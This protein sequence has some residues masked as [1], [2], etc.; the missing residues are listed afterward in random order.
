MA[1]TEIEPHLLARPQLLDF[2]TRHG[3]NNIDH[4]SQTQLVDSV[5]YILGSLGRTTVKIDRRPGVVG[6]AR[7]KWVL[8]KAKNRAAAN[9]FN[10]RAVSEYSQE[11]LPPGTL[12]QYNTQEGQRQFSLNSDDFGHSGLKPLPRDFAR[13]LDHDGSYIPLLSSN[14]S[15]YY[16]AHLPSV[17]HPKPRKQRC[18]P[19][20]KVVL[21]RV[22]VMDNFDPSSPSDSSESE[23]D[24]SRRN[25]RNKKATPPTNTPKPILAPRLNTGPALKFSHKYDDTTDDIE[26]Y[27]G[28]IDLYK[29]Q[30]NGCDHYKL[31]SICV[32]GFADRDLANLIT[33]QLSV[34]FNSWSEFKKQL[35]KKLGKSQQEWKTAYSRARRQPSERASK[36]LMRLT[37]LFI[38]GRGIL[39]PSADQKSTIFDKFL[40]G[41]SPAA[42]KYVL[43]VGVPICY[44]NVA[45]YVDNWEMSGSLSTASTFAN[46]RQVDA[47]PAVS[48]PTAHLSIPVPSMT[49]QRNKCSYCH[50]NLHFTKDCPR[51]PAK[52]CGKCQS[53][54]HKF[55][56]CPKVP[57]RPP[58]PT[59]C[60]VCSAAGHS[61][62]IENCPVLRQ[63]IGQQKNF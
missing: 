4:L 5:K 49:F 36:F 50:N 48:Q 11:T 54:E 20:S 41:I 25:A 22:V 45:D 35:I 15:E 58:A 12:H 44:Y 40:E 59:V 9:R 60:Q 6:W 43:T 7:N 30:Y 13:S 55:S 61:A 2:L 37:G 51:K 31:C 53:E 47:Q 29:A 16:P 26:T 38:K 19:A 3:Y 8:Y 24:H 56:D 33:Q 63:Q 46:V 52:W 27:L 39:S 17:P 18:A 32:Y 1:P 10:P 42:R 34:Y 14:G 21:P 28:L 57:R 62:S 23:D